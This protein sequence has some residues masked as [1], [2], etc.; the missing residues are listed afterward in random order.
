MCSPADAERIFHGE[1][2]DVAG[3]VQ[4]FTDPLVQQLVDQEFGLQGIGDPVDQ[5]PFV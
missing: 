1:L 5:E 2:L 4:T 3:A